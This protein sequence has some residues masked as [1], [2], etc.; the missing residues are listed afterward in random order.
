MFVRLP[1]S[2]EARRREKERPLSRSSSESVLEKARAG[3]RIEPDEAL[4]LYRDAPVLDLAAAAQEARERATDAAVVTY[5]VDRNVNY[6]NVCVTNC[7][8]CGFYRAPGHAESYVLSR[9]EIGRK[10]E[11][12]LAAGG[13]RILLQG[14]HHPDLRLDWYESLLRWIRDS[15]AAIEVNSFSPSE[16]DHVATLEGLPT[17]EVLRRLR[18][19]GQAGLPGGGGEILDDEVRSRVSPLKLGTDGW[20]RIMGEAH[21]L[22]L[23]TT[24]TMVIGFGETLEHRMRHLAR[25]RALQD[26]SLGEHGHGFVAFVAWTAQLDDVP[27]GDSL[28]RRGVL[29]PTPYEYLRTIATSRL[30]LD[31]VPHLQA[32]WPTLGPKVAQVALMYGADDFGSTMMEENVVSQASPA[33]VRTSLDAR[34]IR[35]QIRD[36]GYV[37]AQRDTRYRIVRRFDVEPPDDRARPVPTYEEA[38]RRWASRARAGVRGTTDPAGGADAPGVGESSARATTTGS[39][40]GG[41]EAAQ[42]GTA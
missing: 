16:I 15:Y 13:T 9:D 3:A 17:A 1:P 39:P 7:S 25:L 8:F 21:A 37:P 10:I 11:S 40:A 19:A 20:L 32:S 5:L 31:N 23:A 4:A 27:L 33:K 2:H 14:G 26:R 42:R 12:T 30:F 22:G 34:E 18:D 36:A 41:V 28:R 6:T 38:A 24:C 35:R 29:E